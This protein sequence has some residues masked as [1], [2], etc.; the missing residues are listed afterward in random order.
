MKEHLIEILYTGFRISHLLEELEEK[1][2][3]ID[4]KG[5]DNSNWDVVVDII[6][7]PKDNSAE[8]LTEYYKN[9]EES[10]GNPLVDNEEM[11]C[12]DWLMNDYF[13][14]LESLKK[15]Q[16]IY[17]KDDLLKTKVRHNEKAIKNILSEHIDW[18]KIEFEKYDSE[19]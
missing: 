12:R 2:I 16:D 14:R 6:G 9:K 17:F 4:F 18:L 5:L 3:Q 11:F 1:G 15:E 10:D 7:F 8:I 19:K 13:E